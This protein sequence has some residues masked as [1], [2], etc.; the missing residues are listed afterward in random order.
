MHRYIFQQVTE[1]LKIHIAILLS[2][3]RHTV[4]YPTFPVTLGSGAPG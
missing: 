3:Y 1:D 2:D 4:R